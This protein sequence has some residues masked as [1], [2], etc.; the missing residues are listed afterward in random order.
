[1][2][3]LAVITL[4]AVTPIFTS[5]TDAEVPAATGLRNNANKDARRINRYWAAPIKD[6]GLTCIDN[7]IR[8]GG[9]KPTEICMTEG[10]AL[11]IQYDFQ[12]MGGRW[13]FGIKDSKLRLYDPKGEIVYEYCKDVTHLCIGEEHGLVPNRYSKERPY[14]TLYDEKIHEVVGSLTCDGTDGENRKNIGQSTILKLVDQADVG[15]YADYPLTIVKLRKG[16]TSD[17]TDDNSLWDITVGEP[18]PTATGLDLE[19][20]LHYNADK[21]EWN[22]YVDSFEDLQR[23][24]SA[25]TDPEPAN[26]AKIEI[27]DDKPIV[28]ESVIDFGNK[29]FEISCLGSDCVFDLNGYSL[30]TPNGGSEFHAEFEGITIENGSP[31]EGRDTDLY[32]DKWGGA[33]FLR[34]IAPAVSTLNL[35]GCTLRN[36]VAVDSG[37]IDNANAAIFATDT[38]FAG[39]EVTLSGGAAYVFSGG[40]SSFKNCRFERNSANFGGVAFTASGSSSSFEDCHFE[41][42]NA[43]IDGAVIYS[44]GMSLFKKCR[45]VRNQAGDD[46][47]IIYTFGDSSFDEC[48]FDG[49]TAADNGGVVYTRPSGASSFKNCHFF[50]NRAADDGGIAYTRGTSSFDN[51]NFEGNS[52]GDDGGVESTR[53][54]AISSFKSCQFLRNTAAGEGGAI[55]SYGTSSFENCNFEENDAAEN[56]G[57]IKSIGSLSFSFQNCHFKGN[58]ANGGG[59]AISV[60]ESTLN[61]ERCTF[62]ENFVTSSNGHGGAIMAVDATVNVRACE[63]DENSA[64]ED[65]GAIFLEGGPSAAGSIFYGCHFRGNRATNGDGGGGG[66]IAHFT[67]SIIVQGCDFSGNSAG[68]GLGG[69]IVAFKSETTVNATTFDCNDAFL[70]GAIWNE[71]GSIDISDAEFTGNVAEGGGALVVDSAYSSVTKCLFDQNIAGGGGGGATAYLS[72][73]GNETSTVNSSIFQNNTSLSPDSEFSDDV[74]DVNAVFFGELSQDIRCGYD[75]G[76]CFCDANFTQLPNITTNDLPTTCAGADVG[77]GPSACAG[78][79]PTPP[80]VC[81]ASSTAGA[82]TRAGTMPFKNMDEVRTMIEEK[83]KSMEEKLGAMKENMVLKMKAM[84]MEE[85]T[86]MAEAENTPEEPHH[87]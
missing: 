32:N 63:F 80:S 68:L 26:R 77:T 3:F 79:V 46:G 55:I 73:F 13:Q 83:M 64:P 7:S 22:S 10:E 24:I 21:C 16:Q 53:S 62:E 42:N 56:G 37:A 9:D 70:G 58:T 14:L 72:I 29:Y 61:F 49:N 36:N 85:E 30:V 50:R 45:F 17:P 74:L 38:I 33:F 81:L 19:S 75:S 1:M 39:N 15:P 25:A 4:L 12:P 71:I 18:S 82:T 87:M 5:A 59:G 35:K 52:A 11:C 48:Y 67:A 44:R 60:D 65:G 54:T 34:G 76:N 69:A 8:A 31:Y 40:T 43:N 41:E 57:A 20:F 28:F 78:C 27:C 2:K 86:E 23:Q 51:S 84:E 47:G 66:A 6:S